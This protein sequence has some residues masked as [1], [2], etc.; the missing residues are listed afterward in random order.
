VGR[1]KSPIPPYLYV[2]FIYQ[3]RA[4][5]ILHDSQAI[6]AWAITRTLSQNEKSGFGIAMATELQRGCKSL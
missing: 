3:G 4:K 1:G 5:M 2:P 6:N